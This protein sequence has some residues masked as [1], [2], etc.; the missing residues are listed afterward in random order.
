M[1]VATKYALPLLAKV[2]SMYTISTTM[3]IIGIYLTELVMICFQVDVDLAV[4][5]AR[6]AFK[7]RS[8]WRTMDAS[9]R[10]KLMFKLAD[11]ILEV[12]IAENEL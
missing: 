12:N 7:L 5:A 11:L 6:E 2:F 9:Q 10:G 3:F 1:L 8:P 4:G